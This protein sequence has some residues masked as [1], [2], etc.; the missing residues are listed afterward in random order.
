MSDY[1]DYILLLLQP[2]LD[3]LNQLNDGQSPHA[4]LNIDCVN[5]LY[6]R[7]VNALQTAACQFIPKHKANFYK[8]RWNFELD[9][10]KENAIKFCR[11]WTVWQT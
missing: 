6:D 11:I 10:L 2:V 5:R 4:K 9:E 3:E 8:F 7:V 1:R